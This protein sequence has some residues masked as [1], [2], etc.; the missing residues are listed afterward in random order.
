MI[1]QV[2]PTAWCSDQTIRQILRVLK[3]NHQS[4][5]VRAKVDKS[6]SRERV[7]PTR[8]KQGSVC[9]PYGAVN[10]VRHHE[11]RKQGPRSGSNVFWKES[12]DVHL[13]TMYGWGVRVKG[14]SGVEV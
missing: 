13:G 1:V 2:I 14:W 5:I 6:L 4:I 9:T 12:F 11:G 8:P 7:D 3:W 10:G